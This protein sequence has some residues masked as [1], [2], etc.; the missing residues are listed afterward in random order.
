MD[1]CVLIKPD[2]SYKNDLKSFRKEMLN[3]MSS[4]YEAGPFKRMNNIERMD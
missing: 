3:D 4:I 2:I 1:K